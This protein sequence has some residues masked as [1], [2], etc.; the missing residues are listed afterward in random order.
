MKSDEVRTDH[1]AEKMIVEEQQ[2]SSRATENQEKY[3]E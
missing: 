2:G 1:Q 3:Q